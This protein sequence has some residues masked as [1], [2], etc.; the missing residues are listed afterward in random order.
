[1]VTLIKNGYLVDPSCQIEGM[2]DILIKDSTIEA[3]GKQLACEEATVIDASGK[4][5]MPGLID[6]HVHLREPGFEYKE[7]IQTGTMAAA[8]GGYTTICPMPNTKPSIDSIELV[9]WINEKAKEEGVV[10]I[11]PIG[12]IT[13]GQLGKEL[14]DL[15]G[16]VEHGI[17]AVSE[18]GKSVMETKLYME[19]MKRAK[20]AGIPVFAHCEDRGLVR[21]GVINA[22]SKAKELSMPGITNA[23]EDVIVA[24]DILMAKEAGAALHL[25][26]C[27]TKDSVT[28]VQMAK[29]MGLPV[30]A[31]VCPHHFVLC[32]EDIPCDDANYK[33]NPPL[34]SKEDVEALKEGLRSGIM[35]VIAT[36]HAPHSEEEKQES[37]SVAPFG[38]VGL[39]TALPLTYTELVKTGVLSL[40]QMVDKMSTKPA[41]ILNLD[42]GS[43]QPGKAADLIVVDLDREYTIDVHQFASKGKNSPFHGRKVYGRVELTMVDGTVVYKENK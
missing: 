15:E 10:R 28:F 12:A 41:S 34:R 30:T 43:L 23:V 7:T 1:M 5:I 20:D 18:D 29:D 4:Y 31:E 26:H 11:C 16:M 25:C 37:M 21:G 33:M 17:V 36:D 14:A 35:E 38:I 6:L 19:A 22:G 2:Y 27:S 42:R 9:D 40:M 13:K 3:V 32:D 39:E 24:R 8:K